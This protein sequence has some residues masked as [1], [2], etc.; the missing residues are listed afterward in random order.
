[1]LRALGVFLAAALTT[2]AA[3]AQIGGAS[4]RDEAVEHF[5]KGL[6]LS[7][8]EHWDA[9][10]AE[11]MT[12]SALYP[13]KNAR[14]NAAR[15]L[16]Q[17]ARFDE[18]L[19]IWEALLGDFRAKLKP[20]EIDEANQKIADLR[21][22]VGAIAVTA[23]AAGARVVVDGIE[24]GTTPLAA[25]LKV[26]VG[27]RVVRVSKE[28]YAPFEARVTVAHDSLVT[29]DV[30][31]DPLARAGR[32]RVTEETGK[33]LDVVVDG[34]VVG[35]TPVYEGVVATGQHVVFL[36]GPG[37]R[38]TAPASANV[39]LDQTTN[40]RLAAEELGGAAQIVPEPASA[41]VTLDGVPLGRG[42]WE[43]ALRTGSHKVEA[44]Q[45]GYFGA[46]RSFDVAKGERSVVRIVL[47]RD[48]ASPLWTK[49]RSY[50][51]AVEL[52]AGGAF[53][54]ALGSGYEASCA[55]PGTD[56]YDR[57]R[58]LALLVGVRGAY[59][60][61][62]AL[63]IEVELGYAYARMRT[64]RTT[65]LTGDAGQDVPVD[66]DDTVTVSGPLVGASVAYAFVQRPVVLAG[67]LGG[68]VIVATASASRTGSLMVDT[69][70]LTGNKLGTPVS[71]SLDPSG[72]FSALKPVGFV[73]PEVRFGVPIGERL[74]VGAG[75][76]L[77]VGLADYRP[78]LQQKPSRDASDVHNPEYQGPIGFLPHDAAGGAES[79]NA[80]RAVGTF[81]L[82][83]ARIFTRLAF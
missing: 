6:E 16:E 41:A 38:G 12:A 83:A 54:A 17:L 59:Q 56:C 69:D 66:I 49:G 37:G 70:T 21:T 61:T 1:M 4:K 68:G 9:A 36:R 29:V 22:K 14:K 81:V 67:A 25:P 71:R 65:Q 20:E 75:I 82:P 33:S 31:L 24:R 73:A 32:L 26:A 48:E 55:R 34:S 39:V 52:F 72:T 42:V 47:E 80:E 45:N 58:P 53:G 27:T 2:Q 79:P 18:A 15:C 30:R 19:A 77:L 44:S 64:A 46:V 43:G 10:L 3:L 60:L 23:S 74:V 13:L 7:A 40:L 57:K 76:G 50:P 5:K 62:R 8:G 11:F 51:F 35:K 63:A 78:K 28:G